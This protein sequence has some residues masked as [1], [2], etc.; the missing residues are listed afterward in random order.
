[1]SKLIFSEESYAIIGACMEVHNQLGPGFLESVYQEALHVELLLRN[2]PHFQQIELPVYY[3]NNRLKKCFKADYLCYEN[4]LLEIKA[5]KSITPTEKGIALNYLKAA[6]LPLILLVNFG[7]E[8]LSFERLI[9]GE[10]LR[11]PRK[12]D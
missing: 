1:M 10:K 9:L 3:K 2:I 5:I 8:D 6:Q 4:I 12:Y 11:T 7:E